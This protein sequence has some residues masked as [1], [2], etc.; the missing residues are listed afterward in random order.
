[1]PLQ[2][3]AG[4]FLILSRI[5]R[6]VAFTGIS[7]E[8][9]S[10]YSMQLSHTWLLVENISG[11]ETA[12]KRRGGRIRTRKSREQ[13]VQRSRG[14]TPTLKGKTTNTTIARIHKEMEGMNS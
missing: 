1:V 10:S 8:P 3:S 12:S 4:I 7:R 11:R 2:I 5:P 13:E 14:C 9:T 6:T